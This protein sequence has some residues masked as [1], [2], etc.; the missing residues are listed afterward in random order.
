MAF[1]R[2]MMTA[3]ATLLIGYAFK[4]MMARVEAQ[5]EAIQQRA[6]D[7]RDVTEFKKLKQDPK[8]GEYY[9]ED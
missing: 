5:G 2:R 7:Q 1:V 8:T 9:A 3:G 4:K 6:E